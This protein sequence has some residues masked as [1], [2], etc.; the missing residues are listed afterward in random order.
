MLSWGEHEKSFIT[1]GRGCLNSGFLR[2]YSISLTESLSE[3]H[4][5]I[6]PK[7]L[8]IIEGMLI[9]YNISA[10]EIK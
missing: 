9:Y 3:N 10:G 1:S 7:W 2:F 8:K 6:I 4:H 5:N